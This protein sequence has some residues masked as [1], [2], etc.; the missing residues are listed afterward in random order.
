M[1]ENGSVDEIKVEEINYDTDA[2]NEVA[3]KAG[4]GTELSEGKSLFPLCKLD[5][6]L[7]VDSS[8]RGNSF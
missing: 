6:D 7:V 3:I 1:S 8:A 2:N 5:I 4:D